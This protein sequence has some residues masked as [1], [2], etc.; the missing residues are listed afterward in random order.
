MKIL[1][2][3]NVPAPYMVNYFNELGKYCELT[4][5]FEKATSTERDR[6]W[7]EYNFINFKG[8][9][10]K[11]LSTAVDMAFCP[12][13]VTY[14]KKGVYDFIISSTM[15]TPTG[16]L[17]IEYMK[18]RGIPYYLESEGGF[19]KDGKGLKEKIKKI[20]MSRATG[21]FSTTPIGDNY[22]ITYGADRNKIYKYPFTSLYKEDILLEPVDDSKK[23]CIRKEL[24]IIEEKMIISVG[25][26]I[27]RKGFDVLINSAGKLDKNIGIYI[28]GGEP[29]TEYMELKNKCN[30]SNIHFVGFKNKQQ[31]SEYYKAADLFVL[32]TR[33][34]IW[35]LVINEAMAYGLPVI[36]TNRCI[37][38]IELI[39]FENGD[40][41]S[42]D[43][44]KELTDSINRIIY[45]KNKLRKMGERSLEKIQWYTFENMAKVHMDFFNRGN[46]NDRKTM[47][48]E[49]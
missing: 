36:T 29:S 48:G 9:I 30:A 33:E 42:I 24:G 15:A 28:I 44:E 41:I 37:A 10:L 6:S 47:Y 7:S 38:G 35:G 27:H 19:A 8:I 1:Y 3:V 16:I 5:I 18:L 39:N 20:V 13:I 49:K 17:A 43:S 22:F 11:G 25:Q 31:L 26:F 45:D 46:V 34:D 21:Y 4:V 12:Q 2:M 23:T 40:I 14:L 32:P